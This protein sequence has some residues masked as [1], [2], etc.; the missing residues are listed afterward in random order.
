MLHLLI[1]VK[2]RHF[3]AL[4]KKK[5]SLLALKVV[6]SPPLIKQKQNNKTLLIQIKAELTQ[7]DVV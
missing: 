5:P 3:I 2:C 6:F 1:F 4:S 7:L